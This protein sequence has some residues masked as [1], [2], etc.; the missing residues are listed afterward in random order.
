MK[1]RLARTALLAALLPAGGCSGL[2]EALRG[3]SGTVSSLLT[4]ALY[5]AAVAAPIALSYWLYQ[6][7]R[8]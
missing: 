6:K 8:N 3:V 5:L 4:V 7:D 2:G 1:R